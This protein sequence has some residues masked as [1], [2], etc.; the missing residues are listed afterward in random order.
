MGERHGEL[1]FNR[2]RVSGWGDEKVLDVDGGDD[3]TSM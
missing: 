3:Y 2:Y 1:L